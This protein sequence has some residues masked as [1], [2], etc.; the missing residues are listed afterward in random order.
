MPS[1]IVE[2]F[3]EELPK[4]IAGRILENMQATALGTGSYRKGDHAAALSRLRRQ[5]A[6]P[7]PKPVA[8]TE[9]R[10]REAGFEVVRG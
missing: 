3:L 9:E 10:M 6:G 4:L 1:W 7:G 5:A 2:G 8:P